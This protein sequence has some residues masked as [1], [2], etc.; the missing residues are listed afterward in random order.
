MRARFKSDLRFAAATALLSGLALFL[1]WEGGTDEQQERAT[2]EML[3]ETA[4]RASVDGLI[5]RNPI[6]VGVVANRLA[7]VPRVTGVAIFTIDNEPLAV[8]GS[9]E[10]GTQFTHPIVLDDMVLG[11]ARIGLAPPSTA[12]VWIRAGL[13]LAALLTVALV[14]AFWRHRMR[15]VAPRSHSQ[16]KTGAPTAPQA[17]TQHLLVGNLQNQFALSRAERDRI[18]NR[19]L[20]L[21]ERVDAIYLGKSEHLPGT[22]LLMAL[23]ATTGDNRAR[24]AVCAA[25][26]LAQYLA[27]DVPPGDYRFGLHTLELRAGQSSPDYRVVVE[28]TALISAM[29]R[30]GTIM[31]SE[32]FFAELKEPDGLGTESF[33]HPML[34]DLTTAGGGCHLIT[35]LD[36][37]HQA[38][39]DCQVSR[40]S[41]QGMNPE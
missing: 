5:A 27:R 20:A 25:F 1:V 41:A 34:R 37:D 28:D 8:S 36:P 35:H 38:L 14:A 10:G 30:P 26:L 11:F 4:A 23:P 18:A 2:G 24:E 22:G 13:S 17:A 6:E 7:G 12:S 31:A 3:V 16:A 9:L 33:H 21:A 32:P 15:T 39:I 40:L 19:A 29:A